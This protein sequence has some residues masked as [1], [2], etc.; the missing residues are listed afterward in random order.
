[1][2]TIV[3][4]FTETPIRNHFGLGASVTQSGLDLMPFAAAMLLI[5]PLTGRLSVAF[6]GRR[7]LLSGCVFAS[8]AYLALVLWHAHTWQIMVS[9]GLL[10]IGMAMGYAAMSNLVV[11]AV[12]QSQTGVATGMNT[13]IRNIG[14]AVG[15]GVA[16]SF[17]VSSL[18]HN[19]T[20]AEHGYILAFVVSALALLI[21][22][23]T[24]LLIPRHPV[25]VHQLDRAD[26]AS[27]M[28]AGAAAVA[29]TASG[30][31]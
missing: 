7:V 19:G 8:F 25:V 27:A 24:A 3:P 29:G 23:G 28:T 16:T 12:P 15:A 4:Q 14:S 5:A 17:V 20:P 21:A 22:A 13:N 6:G 1:M 10:G 2:F 26:E 11:Q 9:S 31:E 30:I 18:L